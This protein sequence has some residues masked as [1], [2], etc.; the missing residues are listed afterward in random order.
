M[1]TCSCGCNQ[2]LSRQAIRKHQRGQAVPRLVAA[3]V[4]A[5][6]MNG[7]A[8]NPPRPIPANELRRSHRYSPPSLGPPADSEAYGGVD[9]DF[10]MSEIEHDDAGI[11]P[12]VDSEGNESVEHMMDHMR[13]DVWSGLHHPPGDYSSSESDGEGGEESDEI[14]DDE[15]NP[16]GE[17]VDWQEELGSKL[18]AI[19]I[20]GEEFERNAARNG[21]FF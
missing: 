11:D 17:W 4:R 6:Q 1:P 3:A 7:S 15:D 5:F 8:V 9:D 14:E 21:E 18:S 2:N 13:T 20:L 19:D 12:G 10:P 16:D